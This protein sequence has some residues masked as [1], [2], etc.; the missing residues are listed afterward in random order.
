MLLYVIVI[1][2]AVEALGFSMNSVIIGLSAVIAMV[3]GFGL[4]D[5][6]TINSSQFLT[7]LSGGAR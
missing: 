5:S 6:K 4:Q 2:L 7:S 1:L 3:L